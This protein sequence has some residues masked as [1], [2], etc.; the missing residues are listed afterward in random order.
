[1]EVYR[2]FGYVSGQPGQPSTKKTIR[3]RPGSSSS[4]LAPSLSDLQVGARDE[5]QAFQDWEE[6]WISTLYTPVLTQQGW[7]S[8]QQDWWAVNGLTFRLLDL[9]A[10]LRIAV[11]EQAIGLCIEV[12]C[13][14]DTDE[15]QDF[16]VIKDP[17][18]WR[19]TTDER[20]GRSR[21][22]RKKIKDLDSVLRTGDVAALARANKQ[23]STEI[24]KATWEGTVK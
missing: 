17:V 23:V 1:M 22:G 24:R 7:W 19:V 16:T 11:Y 9:P 14:D 21:F 6:D 20:I 8:R 4:L 3:A 5:W 13:F 15:N 18:V 2:R 10:E 12:D